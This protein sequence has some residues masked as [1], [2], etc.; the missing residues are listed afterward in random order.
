MANV[1]AALEP[2][3]RHEPMNCGEVRL[4][5]VLTDNRAVAIVEAYAV[6][7]DARERG[8]SR[9]RFWIAPCREPAVDGIAGSG[10]FG[11]SSWDGYAA[12][13]VSDAAVEALHDD[14]RVVIK[15]IDKPDLY[16]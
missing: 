6:G 10:Q 15:L 7:G 13:A 4:Q 8:L 11:P 1:A 14:S 12:A 3:P 2:H 9:H 16:R 5:V